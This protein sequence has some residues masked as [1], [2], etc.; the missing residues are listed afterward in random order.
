MKRCSKCR[1]F[2]ALT[3]FHKS[4][5]SGDGHT[6]RCKP[7]ATSAAKEWGANNPERRRKIVADWRRNNPDAEKGYRRI[8]SKAIVERVN[9]WRKDNPDRFA[10]HAPTRARYMARWRKVNRQTITEWAELNKWSMRARV[11]KR[12]AQR[13]RATPTWSDQTAVQSFY[14]S[15]DALNMLLGEWHHVDHIVPLQSDAVCG[16]H[17]HFN[18]QILTA[19]Q[20]RLKSNRHWPDKP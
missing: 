4:K 14:K 13:K 8:N 6:N 9:K 11:A 16:L 12:R 17:T 10:N 18:L 1:E 15:A 7:C 2:K 5:A 19:E 20:N 3:D